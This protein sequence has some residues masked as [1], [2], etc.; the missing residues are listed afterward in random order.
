MKENKKLMKKIWLLIFNELPP[1][2]V[3]KL[4]VEIDLYIEEL[5]QTQTEKDTQTM[6]DIINN[7]TP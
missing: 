4:K 7:K 5:L 2:Q 1:I 3:A 6:L